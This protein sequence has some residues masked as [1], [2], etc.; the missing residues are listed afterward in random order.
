MMKKD[1]GEVPLNPKSVDKDL[2]ISSIFEFQ[3][4]W[5]NNLK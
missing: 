2:F 4:R 1:R 3:E 5:Q